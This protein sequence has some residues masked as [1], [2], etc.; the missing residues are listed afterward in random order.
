[1]GGIR[2]RQVWAVG[3]DPEGDRAAEADRAKGGL[4]GD[5]RVA[6]IG[7]RR[8][9]RDGEAAVGVDRPRVGL[10]GVPLALAPE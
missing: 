10:D 4:L 3:L 1:M 6:T 9:N 5:G 8:G 7:E 2:Q